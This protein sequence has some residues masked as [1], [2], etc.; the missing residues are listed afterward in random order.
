M[1]LKKAGV[2][3]TMDMGAI[4]VLRD[5]ER[6]VP[7]YNEFRRSFSLIT[8]KKMD[9]I[10]DDPTTVA[11]LRKIYGEDVESVDMLAGSLAESPRATGFAFSNTQFQ[12]FILAASRRLMT[13][14]FFTTDYTAATVRFPRVALTWQMLIVCSPYSI[15]KKVW[16]GSRTQTSG[17]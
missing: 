3:Y 11:M 5:R 1:S 16:T 15:H 2:P 12:A 4:D 6:G 9:D 14:R 8:A 10:S 13:D 7:R 17:M